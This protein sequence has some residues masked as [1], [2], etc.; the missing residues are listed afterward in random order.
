MPRTA[1]ILLPHTP[2]HVVQRGHNRA[3]VFAEAGDYRY[4]LDTLIEWKKLLRV[5]VYAYC[6]MTN[7]VHLI[8]EPGEAVF[9]VGRL[10]RRLAGRQTRRVNALEGRTGTLWEGRYKASPV[11]TERYLLA[12]SRYVE[13]NPVRAAMVVAPRAYPWSSYRFKVGGPWPDWLDED[14]CYRGLG[15]S[16]SE[17]ARRYREFVEG[18]DDAEAQSLIRAAVNR[19]QLTGDRRF[20]EEVER[21]IGCRIELRGRGRPPNREK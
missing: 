10:M 3:S 18:E 14:P 7:H 8:L 6:L 17:R 20:I 13:L 2:H 1:R 19:N 11:Q 16:R 9:A 12:C 4:Y 5:K 15:E 21:R